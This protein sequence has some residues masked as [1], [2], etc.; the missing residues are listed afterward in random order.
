[1]TE[2]VQTKKILWVLP[3][4]PWPITSGGKSRQYH[5]IKSL[6]RRGHRITLL[7]QSKVAVDQEVMAELGFLED[8]I[9]VPRRKLASIK[10]VLLILFSRWPML[11]CING[12]NS[13]LSSKFEQLLS[14]QWDIIQIEH[15]YSFQPYAKLLSLRK[16]PFILTEHNV[17]SGLGAATYSRLPFILKL[18]APIDRW[19]YRRW[20]RDVMQAAGK[21]IAVTKEDANELKAISGRDVNVVINGVDTDYFESVSPSLAKKKV[22]FIGNYEYAPNVDAV[23]WLLE[24][25]MPE[26]WKVQPDIK[27]VICGYAMPE[28][29]SIRWEDTRIQWEGFVDNLSQIQKN[30]SIFIAPLR[31]GGGSKLKVLEAMAAGLPLVS[32]SQGVSGLDVQFGTHYLGGDSTSSLVEGI[33]QFMDDPKNA[34]QLAA[35]SRD[36]A[37]V[38]HDWRIAAQ[39][40]EHVYGMI[41]K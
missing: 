6:A 31:S 15:S 26:V 17:E 24:Q 12:F 40:L 8:V 23:E 41:S 18:F 36:Y 3:Y 1:M 27:I 20:E 10:T 7:V 11:A 13:I 25:I 21:V 14:Q 5:L 30:S 39:Q 9:V 2:V 28:E 29:W 4:L 22:L 34:I 32:T 33:C 19:K 35:S 37:R 38:H 16:T